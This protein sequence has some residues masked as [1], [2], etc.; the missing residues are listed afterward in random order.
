MILEC[1]THLSSP[2]SP[3]KLLILLKI[4]TGINPCKTDPNQLVDFCLLQSNFGAVYCVPVQ[5]LVYHIRLLREAN[6]SVVYFLVLLHGF[7]KTN[8]QNEELSDPQF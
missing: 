2:I 4:N 1:L 6:I 8:V 5:F 3:G 7:L